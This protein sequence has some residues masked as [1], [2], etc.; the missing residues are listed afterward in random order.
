MH[1]HTT[2]IFTKEPLPD[3]LNTLHNTVHPNYAKDPFTMFGAPKVINGT[4]NKPSNP[5]NPFNNPH[6][7]DI[8]KRVKEANYINRNNNPSHPEQTHMYAQ[9]EAFNWW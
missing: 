9:S 4:R 2:F 8:L 3:F 1:A 7:K 5:D 6:G